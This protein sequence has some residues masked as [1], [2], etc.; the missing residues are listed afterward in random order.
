[1]EIKKEIIFRTYLVFLVLVVFSLLIV[2][3]TMYIQL[4][5]GKY[6]RSMADSAHITEE[7]IAAER[8][9]ILS[10]SGE[11]LSTS[12]P[13]FDIYVDFQAN[14]LI[15]DNGKLFYLYRDSLAHGLAGLFKDKKAAEYKK[16]LDNG[17]KKKDRF[18]LLK[19]KISFLDYEDLK[20]L[21][22]VR[23]GKNKSGFIGIVR[24]KRLYPYRSLANRTIGIAR[25]NNKVGLEKYYNEALA[26]TNG[27][28]FVRYIAGGAGVPIEGTDI[29]PVDGNDLV[30]TLDV[31]IQEIAHE[32]LARMMVQNE[33]E[34]GTCIVMEVKTGKVRAIAN[35]GRQ[36]DG[37]Y[38]EDYNYA[39]VP[40]E[41]GST[42]KLLTLISVLEDGHAS[43][44]SKVDLENGR[45]KVANQVVFDSERHG[46]REATLQTAFE[47]SSNVAM[48]KVAY[49][50]Y[51]ANPKGYL[52][53]ITKMHLDTL[54]GI[55]LT[56]EMKPRIYK[57]G[58]RMWS[59]TTLPWM[60]FGYNL[61]IS[62]L[63]TAMM[64]N[65]IANNGVMVRPYLVNALM[66]DGE[67]VE[68][69]MPVVID[70]AICSPQVLRDVKLSLE[71][72]VTN[73]TARRLK[74]DKYEFAAKTGTSL[75]AD[76]GI[77]YADRVYQSSFAGY[78][79]AQDP[80]YTI[81]VVIRN[82]KHAAN[83]YGGTVAGPVFR[84]VADRLYGSHIY[85][86]LEPQ[87]P[88]R[89]SSIYQY[90][91]IRETAGAVSSYLNWNYRDSSTNNDLVV[92]NYHPLRGMSLAGRD[93]AANKMPALTGITLRDALDVCEEK[94]LT[95]HVKGKGRLVNQSIAAGE[96]IRSGQK[97]ILEFNQ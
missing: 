72:V 35:L 3:K 86:H 97:I 83:F 12:I 82:K 43:L 49:A 61:T 33:A 6:W 88:R 57:P 22:L 66:K 70:S 69:K 77:S 91:A 55:D 50:F 5:Q 38:W 67:L 90:A 68:E 47:R 40:S 87:A 4:G 37:T 51:A 92:L 54:T 17:F 13:E 20:K 62:P 78:F 53:H 84:E 76:K 71:G 19:R 32:A 39:L 80:Q 48:A 96:P 45:W 16:I 94:G 26:G 75:V 10:E 30:T 31:N 41:P 52:A 24:M 63:Q 58:D 74:S 36:R 14:G 23:L 27:S 25:E 81:V 56:G 2:S 9:A 73:G 64:Y 46:L 28:R 15:E 29:E 34:R 44:N 21:P 60:A 95:V 8:G 79:P 18:F 11:V 1:M 65:A 7:Q 59:K 89:D 85:K 42:F 93:S